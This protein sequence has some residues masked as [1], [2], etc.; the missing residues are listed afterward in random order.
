MGVTIYLDVRCKALAKPKNKGDIMVFLQ[1]AA[2]HLAIT[3][4]QY[5]LLGS[6]EQQIYAAQ[7]E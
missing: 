1:T 7:V 4:A 5:F 2:I 6:S 3:S